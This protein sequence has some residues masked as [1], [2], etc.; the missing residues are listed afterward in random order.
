[1][2]KILLVIV[3]FSF[4]FYT[5]AQSEDGRLKFSA[6]SINFGSVTNSNN[7]TGSLSDFQTLAP[8]S[9]LLKNPINNSNA[10]G[11]YYDYD[12]G[13]MFNVN[14]YFDILNKNGEKSKFNT[15]LR[16]GITFTDQVYFSQN[17][18]SSES[19]RID[20]LTSS[21]DGN[22]F[23]VDSVQNENYFMDYGS[24]QLLFDVAYI[25]GSNPESRLSIYGGLGISLGFSFNASTEISFSKDNNFVSGATNT[26]NSNTLNDFEYK[27]E[28]FSNRGGFSAML[29]VPF[30][31]EFRLSKR[32]NGWGNSRLFI[33][34]RTGVTYLDIPELESRLITSAMWGCGFK[35]NF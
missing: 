5:I 6:I 4:S 22:T 19:F 27:E 29:S 34:G 18:Y 12:F 7:Y 11:Y 16:F 21:R 1:M 10:K 32:D 14:A 26:Y 28:I 33:E 3:L 13:A 24:D 31:L 23:F 9:E 20:T 35:Y 25:I 8:N 15:T 17:S 30:G 2:K